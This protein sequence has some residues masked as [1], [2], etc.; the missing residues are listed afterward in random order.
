MNEADIEQAIAEDLEACGYRIGRDEFEMDLITAG[1]NSV[2]LVRV[3]TT[4][5]E[6]YD[7][8]FETS[9]FLREPVTVTRLAQAIVTGLAQSAST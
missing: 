6:R 8:E 7:I 3:L 9:G 5:E 2:N 1:I 4:L